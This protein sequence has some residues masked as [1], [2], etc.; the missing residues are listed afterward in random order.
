MIKILNLYAGIGGNRKLWNG[1]IEVTAIENNPDIAKIYQDFF[2]NDKVIVCD[3]HQYLLEHFKEFDFIWS[4]PPCPSHSDIRRMGASSGQYKPI[5]P[6][7]KLYEEIIFLQYYFKGKWVVENVKPYYRPLI[8]FQ[9][10][11]RHCF[12]SNFNIINIK[13]PPLRIREIS[14][15]GNS[16]DLSKYK[17]NQRKDQIIRNCVNPELGLHIFEM[18]FKKPQLTLE[19]NKEISEIK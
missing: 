6:D 18:A 2:P 19:L 14:N 16:F 12:W 10:S 17:L 4:S 3:A 7:M 11:G 13:L 8:E 1:D 9:T 5:F 15:K